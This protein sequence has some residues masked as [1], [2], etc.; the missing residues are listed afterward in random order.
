M[1]LV[2]TPISGAVADTSRAMADTSQPKHTDSAVGRIPR[3][4]KSSH[5]ANDQPGEAPW[6]AAKN[7]ITLRVCDARN[8]SITRSSSPIVAGLPR[9]AQPVP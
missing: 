2:P 9:A 4:I 3:T 6:I 5:H 1:K 7:R 8:R